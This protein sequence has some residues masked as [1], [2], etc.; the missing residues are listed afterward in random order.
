M[1]P[2]SIDIH[3]FGLRFVL[4]ETKEDYNV[5]MVMRHNKYII[6]ITCVC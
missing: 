2:M 6:I 5:C 3:K 1:D 4:I